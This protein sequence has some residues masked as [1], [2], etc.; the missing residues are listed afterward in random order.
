M[1]K[2]TRLFILLALV[3]GIATGGA[4]RATADDKA[5][6]ALVE[7]VENA[8]NAGVGFMDYVYPGKVIEL[9][10]G[11]KLAL[12]YF[13]TCL[14][15]T[16]AGGRV[17]VAKGAS[18]VAGGQVSAKKFPCQ[19]ARMVVTAETG[20]AGA[21]VSRV[22]PFAG[23]DWAE[24]T[25]KTPE[26]VFKWRAAAGATALKVMDMDAEPPKL[27]WQGQVEGGHFAYP[28]DAPKLKVG[29]PYQ[30]QVSP[31]GVST[32][33]AMFSVDPDL[34]VPDT[35]MARVVLLGR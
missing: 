28:A 29:V 3:G 23:Q 11:G 4:L 32:I 30:I 7:A 8:A 1:T 2:I 6:V 25:V 35:V 18:D 33:V 12:S 16:I 34:D 24:F 22:T 26:P 15:E 17:T 21:T 13:D 5:A 10:S 27:I 9:G 14:T 31:P 20:E 19:R